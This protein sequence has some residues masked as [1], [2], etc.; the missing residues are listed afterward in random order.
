[1]ERI[2]CIQIVSECLIFAYLIIINWGKCVDTSTVATLTSENGSRKMPL[3][4]PSKTKDTE[5]PF[6]EPFETARTTMNNYD[7]KSSI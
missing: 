5:A 6:W 7:S 1:M 2:L 4:N 3:P